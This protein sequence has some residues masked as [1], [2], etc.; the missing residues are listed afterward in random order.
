[1]I[2][3]VP[4]PMTHEEDVQ[5]PT[6]I[7][8]QPVMDCPGPSQARALWHARVEQETKHR[9]VKPNVGTCSGALISACEKPKMAVKAL[10]VLEEIKHMGVKPSVQRVIQQQV[11]QIVDV[12]MPITQEEVVQVPTI[13]PQQRVMQQQVEQMV[14][15]P[16]PVTQ[17]KIVEVPVPMT[18]DEVVQVLTVIPQQGVMQQQ[19][20]QVVAVPVPMTQEEIVQ[21]PTFITQQCIT[22]QRVEQMAGACEQAY[23]AA[24]A[25]EFLD[26]MKQRVFKPDT[27]LITSC[28][29]AT[30]A[31]SGAPK[32][33]LGSLV[34]CKLEPDVN[35][36][37]TLT[38]ACEISNQDSSSEGVGFAHFLTDLLAYAEYGYEI[39]KFTK[40]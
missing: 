13:I 19:L 17:E 2:V 10:E 7:P 38:R 15:V 40:C 5:V 4:V 21:V 26:E 9:G 22:Q 23:L 29:K 24:Y 20:E 28:E 36:C 3:K 14:K 1:M 8:Q 30:L 31:D 32:I 12:P 18:Q 34:L 33:G 27:A 11:K 6:I 25:I 35:T 39:S 37:T 16:V